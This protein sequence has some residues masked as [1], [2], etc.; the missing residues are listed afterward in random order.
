[1]FHML[2]QVIGY[3]KTQSFIFTLTIRYIVLENAI[4][5]QKK[6]F[7]GMLGFKFW[8]GYIGTAV[9]L[10][11]IPGKG[12]SIMQLGLLK[13]SRQEGTPLVLRGQ[14]TPSCCHRPHVVWQ[15]H[16]TDGGACVSMHSQLWPPECEKQDFSFF[17]IY[18]S[19]HLIKIRI[20]L[21]TEYFWWS[22]LN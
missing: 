12:L 9:N 11:G 18:P 17:S 1:M 16:G 15:R 6:L 14:T 20:I 2:L 3:A 19:I 21:R 4:L 7:F 5:A 10:F 13:A 8:K 22:W